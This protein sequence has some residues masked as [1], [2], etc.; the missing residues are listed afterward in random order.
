MTFSEEPHRSS[1][2]SCSSVGSSDTLRIPHVVSMFNPHDYTSAA[3]QCD[4]TN[5]TVAQM[6]T[7]A[8]RSF[9]LLPH[10][11]DMVHNGHPLD[12]N[13]RAID[14]GI[15]NG[16]VVVVQVRPTPP[17]SPPMMMMQRMIN[18][19]MCTQVPGY[20][21]YGVMPMSMGMGMSPYD[22]PVRSGSGSSY[23]TVSVGCDV[24]VPPDALWENFCKLAVTSEGSASLLNSLQQLHDAT[25]TAGQ[26][27]PLILPRFLSLATN[28]HA[29]KVMIGIANVAS[30]TQVNTLLTAACDLIVPM[31]E[32]TS[33]AEML[34][35]M[36]GTTG[37]AKEFRNAAGTP[38]LVQSIADNIQG[39]GV[40]VNGRKVWHLDDF[41]LSS[42]RLRATNRLRTHKIHN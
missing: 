22:P 30:P 9:S 39:V 35:A 3:L 42:Q 38:L 34:V 15:G 5:L 20:Q 1:S 19:P 2:V 37:T 40:S 16:A 14:A 31:C 23:S 12:E 10:T 29:S 26:L 36:V 8:E 41:S 25:E 21:P 7:H 33:G 6:A 11:F 13:S 4:L 27:L 17:T 18:V 28:H 24:D 32:S